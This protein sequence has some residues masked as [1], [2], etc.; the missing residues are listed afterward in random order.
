VAFSLNRFSQI[1]F[2]NFAHSW[3]FLLLPQR[4]QKDTSP[5]LAFAKTSLSLRKERDVAE[6]QGEVKNGLLC[7]LCAF[8]C[9]LRGFFL[10]TTKGA[11]KELHETDSKRSEK[12]KYVLD[13]P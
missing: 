1:G 10:F 13:E 3:W 9:V 6:R 2:A 4:A 12:F 8:L 11:K 5:C 7:E